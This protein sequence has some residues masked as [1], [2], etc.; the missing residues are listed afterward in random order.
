MAE[1]KPLR[2]LHF[3]EYTVG[4]GITSQGRTVTEGDIVNFCLLYTSRCV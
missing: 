1:L 4:D 3:E 2:G